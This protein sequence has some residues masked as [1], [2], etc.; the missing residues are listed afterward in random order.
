MC[1]K[2]S[3][4][5]HATQQPEQ[6][7]P[8]KSPTPPRRPHLQ[9]RRQQAVDGAAD[10]ELKGGL[11]DEERALDA[12]AVLDGGAH[13]LVTQ[14]AAG[15]GAEQAGVFGRCGRV[16]GSLAGSSMEHS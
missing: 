9:R 4:G 16:L 7:G 5:Q 10:E 8:Q 2:G 15:A 6:P 1:A 11:G 13:V 14:L 12:A 3:R